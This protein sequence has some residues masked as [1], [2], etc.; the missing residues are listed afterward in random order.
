MHIPRTPSG[1]LNF[2]T[3]ATP[4]QNRIGAK[5]HLVGCKRI[6]KR[7]KPATRL[8]IM[9]LNLH[10]RLSSQFS[11]QPPGDTGFKFLNDDVLTA[12]LIASDITTVLAF[13]R[14]NKHFRIIV[15]QRCVWLAHLRD[16]QARGMLSLPPDKIHKNF[17]DLAMLEMID[18]VRR[19]VLEI[20]TLR[21]AWSYEDRAQLLSWSFDI[22][23]GGDMRAGGDEAVIALSARWWI[24]DIIAVNFLTGDS[25]SPF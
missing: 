25:E 23:A 11:K 10:Q 19:V 14:V 22:R 12:I 15:L 16:L 5:A 24:Y 20:A 6:G 13:T 17:E 3:A 7:V 18:E 1:V 8:M 21:V 4:V 2:P 9:F